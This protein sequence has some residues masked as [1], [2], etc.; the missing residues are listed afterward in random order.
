MCVSKF[1]KQFFDTKRY[2]ILLFEQLSPSHPSRQPPDGHI[3]L[4]KLHGCFIQLQVSEQRF[5]NLGGV[6]PY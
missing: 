3:P 1:I 5:P 2:Q 4:T 6:H